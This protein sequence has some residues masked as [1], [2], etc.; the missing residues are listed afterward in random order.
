MSTPIVPV[1]HA[2]LG[3]SRVATQYQNSADFLAYLAAIL[4]PNNE[5]E[6][7]F[8]QVAE[9]VDIDVAE[10]ENLDTIGDIVGISRV[11]P[12]GPSNPLPP[13]Q[14]VLADP[15]YRCLLRAKIVK[16]HSRGLN[17]DIIK[18]LS[19]LFDTD[20]VAIDDNN[21]MT[22]SIGVGKMLGAVEQAMYYLLDILPRPGGVMI[23]YRVMFDST[24]YFGF[25]DQQ[26]ALPFG[27][28]G[29]PVVGG[30]F[31]EEF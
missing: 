9:Q 24:K 30:L 18:G 16:N 21:D 1:D 8:Q 28:E 20:Y 11:L 6:I 26:H 10:G 3:L 13:D 7:V 31:A 15:Q 5:L 19:F 25:A 17:E 23:R 12:G 29:N 14:S 27:E 22:I 4:T 2:A